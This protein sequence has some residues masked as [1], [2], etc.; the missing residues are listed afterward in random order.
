MAEAAHG[1]APALEGKD[2]ANPM[3]MILAAA[4]LLVAHRGRGLPARRTRDPRGDAR[5]RRGGNPHSR[6][7]RPPRHD[8]VHGRGDPPHADEARGLGLA[9]GASCTSPRQAATAA[10]PQTISPA[11]SASRNA[12]ATVGIELGPGAA[13]DLV[14][15]LVAAR[16]TAG[17]AGPTSSRRTR[18]RPRG[19]VPRAGSTRPRGASG[20]RARPSARGGR[21][22]TGAPA[23]ATATPASSQS[24]LDRVRRGSRR[25]PSASSTPGLR[26][27]PRG[28]RSPCRR[29]GAPRRAGAPRAAPPSSRACTATASAFAAT[30]AACAPSAGSQ[31]S[32]AVAKAA[33]RT[34]GCLVPAPRPEPFP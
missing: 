33:S 32:I 28:G 30:R 5:G 4:A 17:R 24:A 18:R 20:S 21:A 2:V 27:A 19:S 15:R 8:G 3:A 13:P 25:A 26:R 7:R 12:A 23:R 31:T 22:R 16:A 6:P 11:S 10:G 9:V 29:R 34:T 1:T 14:G